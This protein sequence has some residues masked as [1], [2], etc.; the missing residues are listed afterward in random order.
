MQDYYESLF[1]T[2]GTRGWKALM[3]DVTRMHETHNNLDSIDTQEQLWFRKGQLSQM[4][5]LLMHQDTVER[6][7][8]ALIAE[9]EDKRAKRAS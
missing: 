9:R 2:Y 7:F 8:S 1:A 6:A 5:W 4:V 3:E